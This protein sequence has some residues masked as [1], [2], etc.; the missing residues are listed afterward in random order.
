V[1]FL[2]RRY[3]W[4]TDKIKADKIKVDKIQENKNL[5]VKMS[6]KL[7]EKQLNRELKRRDLKLQEEQ[8]NNL[9]K[10]KNA[11]K[12]ENLAARFSGEKEKLLPFSIKQ[13]KKSLKF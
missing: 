3:I 10:K 11:K 5:K 7:Q 4:L 1:P 9:V 6:V 12:R 2:L 13:I 8:V